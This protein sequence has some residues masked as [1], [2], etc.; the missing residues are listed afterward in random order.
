M[1]QR[2]IPLLTFI[3]YASCAPKS[4]LLDYPSLV[5]IYFEKK[6]NSLEKIDSPTLE[7]KRLI[8]KTKVEF[9][10]GVLMEENDRLIEK[11]YSKG[12]EGYKNAH[13]IFKESKKLGSEILRDSYPNFDAWLL[14]TSTI[15]FSSSNVS[16]LYWL[17]ASMGGAI[18]SSRGNPFEIVNLPKVAQLLENAILLEPTWGKGA[19]YSAMMSY[20]SSR[21]DLSEKALKESVNMYFE[22]A[23]ILSDSLNASLFVTYAESIHKPFQEKSDYVKKLNYV[24]EMETGKDSEFELSNI[25]AQ[26]RAKW[27][28]SKT[29]ENFL[30]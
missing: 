6:I 21:S 11:D 25:I 1:R 23:L 17:A 20:T 2:L 29:N 4:L 30:E 10:Y 9:A 8:M 15:E 14:G 19:L 3:F 16:D 7:E 24:L 18:K 27:L 12:I 5:S 28:L 22:K 13:S 26:K